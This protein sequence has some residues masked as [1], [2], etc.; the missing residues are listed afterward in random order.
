MC[1]KRARRTGN[2]DGIAMR[3]LNGASR[4]TERCE[5]CPQAPDLLS[6]AAARLVFHNRLTGYLGMAKFEGPPPLEHRDIT[7][8][9][10]HR[11]V[12]LAVDSAAAHQTPDDEHE[13]DAGKEDR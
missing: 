1:G 11:Q 6:G 12:L 9:V 2:L 10:S 5:K 8:R 3:E 13:R 7:A 4:E